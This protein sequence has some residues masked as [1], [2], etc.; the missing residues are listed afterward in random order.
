MS[1]SFTG[2]ISQNFEVPKASW[3]V[4]KA[5]WYVPFAQNRRFVGRQTQLDRL[6]HALFAKDQ[7]PRVAI[8]G[9][10]GMGKTQ[11]A[12][13]VAYRTKGKYPKCSIFW[14]P[15]TNVESLQ[16]AFTYIGQQLGVLGQKEEQTNAKKLVQ[17]HLSQ[18]SAGQ[19]L[20]IVDNVDDIEI[21]NKE[22]KDCLPKSQQGFLVCTTRNRQVAVRIA[23]SNVIEVPEMDEEMAMQLL[24]KSLINQE[25][26]ADHQ[27]AIKLLEQLA[28]LPL[29]AVQAAAYINTNG[30][31]LSEYL[32]LLEEQEKDVV[33]LLS[34]DFADEWRYSDAK[35]PVA[36]TWLISFKQIQE[37]N[38]LAAEYLSF[39]S[40]VDPKGIPQ[41]LLP[42]GQSRKEETDA[43]GTL[44]AYSFVSRRALDHALD[45]HRLVHLVMRSWLRSQK[46]WHIWVDKTLTRLVEVLPLGGHDKRE[47]WTAY[48][49]HAIHVVGLA[50]LCERKDRLLDRVGRCEKTLGHYKAAE[51]AHRQLLEQREKVLGKEHPSTLVSMNGVAQAL[52]DRGKYAEAEVMHR[53]TLAL[54]EKVSG[55][56][57]PSTLVSMNEVAQALSSQGKYAEAEVMHRETL[58]LREKVSG[59]EHPETLV[60]TNNLAQ[61]LSRQGKYAEAEV[62]HQETLALREKVSGKEHPET[63]VIMNNLAQALNSQGKYAEAEVMHRET[64]ALKE[65][66]LGKEH[67]STLVS[68]NNLALALSSQRN[69][70]E[71]EVMHRE[72]LALREKV[73]GKEH[74]LT[75]VSMNNLAQALS[76][77]RNYAEAE[78]MHR[79]TLALREK[80]SGKE[81]PET[82]VIMNN[83]AQA[84][85]SQGKY[86]EAE[87]MYRETLALREKVSGKEHP[88]T[89]V[90]MHNLANALSGL[91]KYVEAIS[92]M[93]Q[94]FRLRTQILGPQ[95]PRTKGSLRSLNKWQR[96]S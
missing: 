53:E 6:E 71:A 45:V 4:P 80:V 20:I 52:S 67:P 42:P 91:G 70:A 75:L 31:G 56:E 36:T 83:M 89:L 40:C 21:W 69:Y 96:E 25:L 41:S 28:F 54:R 59:K 37:L 86:A 33:K 48:L 35:N 2:G 18:E 57:H 7:Q 82:L 84:L 27:I 73:S 8:T 68:M 39:V 77:Q 87:V 1:N 43:I 12:L 72:T 29:A 93:Q 61:T 47:V 5:S 76:S 19:W 85:N 17:S 34:E 55:K 15:A 38:P 14:I 92:L 58:A 81:H 11:I 64:L 63:L 3:E 94:C 23:A 51:W 13:E 10:G 49:P 26:L 66:V 60:I 32:L 9:L 16:Q 24:S 65:K 30:I 88:E 22:L 44:S 46:Q 78:V 79:E 62:M 50:E 74:P 95:H 90:I